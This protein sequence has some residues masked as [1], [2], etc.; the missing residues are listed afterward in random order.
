MPLDS[1][2]FL[3]APAHSESEKKHFNYPQE[4]MSDTIS[5][6]CFGRL[7]IGW[8]VPRSLFICRLIARTWSILAELGD[9]SVGPGPLAWLHR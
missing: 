8:M 6:L 5:I 7:A 1:T 4:A 3:C 9:C 2:L